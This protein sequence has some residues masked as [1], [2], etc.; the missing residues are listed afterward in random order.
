MNPKVAKNATFQHL[1][2]FRM[3]SLRV[4]SAFY[5]KISRMTDNRRWSARLLEKVGLE[6]EK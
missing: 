6:K 4:I 1:I 2:S 5:V 3:F